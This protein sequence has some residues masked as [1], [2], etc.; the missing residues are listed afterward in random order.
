MPPAER[1]RVAIVGIGGIFPGAPDLGRFW[2]NIAGAVDVTRAVPPGRW[3]VAAE[4][5][6]DLSIPTEHMKGVRSVREVVA[7]VE[8]LLAE[9]EA[10]KGSSTPRPGLEAK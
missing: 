8:K 10:S 3:A 6:F 9:R 5:A 1:E 4:E 7:G 2:A